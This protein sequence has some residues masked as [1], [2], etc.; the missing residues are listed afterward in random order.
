MG[1]CENMQVLKGLRVVELA[2]FVAAPICGRM[3]ADYGAEVIKVERPSGDNYR[4]TGLSVS[5]GGTD[6]ENPI[7]DLLNSRKKSVMLNLQDPADMEAMEKLL[8]TADVFLTSN[9]M[10]ALKKMGFDPD[11]L[12]AKY[13]K[14][15]YAMITGYG[16]EGPDKDEPGFDSVAFWGRMGVLRDAYKDGKYPM[17]TPWAVGD[18]ITGNMLLSGVLAAVMKQKQTGEGDF[19]T[20]SLFGSAI[21]S[22]CIMTTF[23]QPKYDYVFPKTRAEAAPNGT[24]Y[25]CADGE[26]LQYGFEDYD[27]FMPKLLEAL[28][29]PELIHDS[30]FD[31]RLHS[32]EHPQE[33]Q[34]IF[35]KQFLL[36]TSKEW[37][38]ILRGM[39][40]V[41]TILPHIKDV[42]TDPQAW[43][44]GN[45]QNHTNR[46]GSTCVLPCPPVRFGSSGSFQAELAPL[47]GENT[48]EVLEG[49][50][51]SRQ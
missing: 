31:T 5:C 45:L 43:A 39:G 35:E 36:K 49:L 18:A 27:R 20:A 21:W 42:A 17:P 29:V 8:E 10:G 13:P 9:R 37:L 12:R 7:F 15:I 41:C 22:N 32:L 51:I 25:C 23:S 19:V 26:W 4:R 24:F 28:G 44:N 38:E 48:A 6:D 16:V 11:T 47:L 14:L 2:E 34:Q 30:M 33:I 40:M 50:G 3:L 1:N 46:N